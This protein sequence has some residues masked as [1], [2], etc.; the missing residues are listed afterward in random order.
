MSSIERL[1]DLAAT[2]ND[3]IIVHNAREGLDIVVLSLEEYER[4]VQA[5]H[6][7]HRNIRQLS[8][9][10][11]IDQINRDI[12]IWRA[13]QESNKQYEYEIA[14]K[15][16]LEEEGP[17]DPFH[18]ANVE[19]KSW[20]STQSI[21]KEQYDKQH[22]VPSV[23]EYETST[24]LRQVPWVDFLLDDETEDEKDTEDPIFIEEPIL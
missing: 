17:F 10:Q 16:E 24:S 8:S 15:K 5:Q 18:Q 13:E 7:L 2:T 22:S 12:A 23:H 21:L 9:S 11:L 6:N 20:H 3:T 1:I 19:E 14:L 4:L